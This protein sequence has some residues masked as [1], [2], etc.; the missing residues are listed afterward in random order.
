MGS[1][2]F[3][4]VEVIHMEVKKKLFFS[5]AVINIEK[6]GYSWCRLMGG[7]AGEGGAEK[8]RR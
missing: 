6:V 7:G 4:N 5:L 8:C 1:A 3:A 2:L